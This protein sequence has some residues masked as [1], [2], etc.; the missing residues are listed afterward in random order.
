MGYRIDLEPDAVDHLRS[1]S[2]RE[3]EIVLDT[4][5]EQLTYTPDVETRNR[6][7]LRSNDLARWELRIG[8][9]RVFYDVIESEKRVR[10]LAIGRKDHER[11]VVGG[12]EYEL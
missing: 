5:E 7:Q 3:R 1:I 10:V 4:V 11:L 6:K 8:D 2:A 9:F 12:R